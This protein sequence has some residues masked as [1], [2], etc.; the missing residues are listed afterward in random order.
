MC[1]RI[2]RFLFLNKLGI[3]HHN[4]VSWRPKI[5]SLFLLFEIQN[6]YVDLS[7]MCL[8]KRSLFVCLRSLW[9]LNFESWN[10]KIMLLFLNQNIFIVLKLFFCAWK[11]KPYFYIKLSI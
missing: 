7:T 8:P 3:K 2:S 5:D 1:S 6:A 11:P 10:A 4:F 9:V